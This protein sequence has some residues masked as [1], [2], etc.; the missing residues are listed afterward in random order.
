LTDPDTGAADRA[1]TGEAG[2]G[3]TRSGRSWVTLAPIIVFAALALIFL[4]QLLRGGST[5]EIASVLIGRPAP[6]TDLAPLDG[7]M[8]G[9]TQLPGITNATFTGKITILNV[10]GSWCA[11]CRAEHPYVLAL[12]NDDR[13]QVVGL[14]Q[15][16]P[17]NNA[18][19]FLYEMGN[20][21]DA[22]GADPN[23]RASIDWGVYGVPESFLIDRN[24]IVRYK[25]IGPMTDARYRDEMMPQIEALLAEQPAPAAPATPAI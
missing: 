22:I 3:E 21:F 2:A 20:P 7:M 24:G 23:G 5:G 14:N 11:P 9:G 17:T 19:S 4:V 10:W 25:M 12:G 6:V 1:A 15:R 8:V 13:I 18:I 16:D